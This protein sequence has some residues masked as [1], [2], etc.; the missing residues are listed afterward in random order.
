V[1][2]ALLSRGLDGADQR[3]MRYSHV[4]AWKL[5]RGLLH[6]C[7]VHGYLAYVSFGW[8]ALHWPA[9]CSLRYMQQHGCRSLVIGFVTCR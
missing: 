9:R 5:T 2:E 1:V 8:G 7:T 3:D 6:D 4:N